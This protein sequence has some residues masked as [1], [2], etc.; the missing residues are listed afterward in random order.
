MQFGISS[1]FQIALDDIFGDPHF[2]EDA[3]WCPAGAGSSVLIRIVRRTP[4]CVERFGDSRAL[5]GTFVVDVRQM[6]APTLAKADTV[7]VAG[8]SYRVMADPV[9]DGLDLVFTIELA[10]T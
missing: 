7:E 5:I 3:L 2:A 9:V 6:E 8:T 4:D 10:L 1:A